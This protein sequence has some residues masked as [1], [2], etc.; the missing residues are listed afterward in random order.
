ME[1]ITNHLNRKIIGQILFNDFT[2]SLKMK[3]N[4]SGQT[5]N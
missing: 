3:N 4:P 1:N 2:V 5:P